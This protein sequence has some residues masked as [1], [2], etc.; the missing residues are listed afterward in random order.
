MSVVRDEDIDAELLSSIGNNYLKTAMIIYLV[1]EKLNNTDN[2][3]L[4]RIESRILHLIDIGK[5]RSNGDISQWR[6][7]EIM[8]K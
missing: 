3:F 4:E 8:L 5:I 2:E 6:R 7:S 1:G